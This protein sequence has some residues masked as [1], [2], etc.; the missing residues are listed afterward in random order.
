MEHE[1]HHG[2][3]KASPDNLAFIK[4]L[5]EEIKEEVAKTKEFG[6]NLDDRD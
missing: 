1:M 5:R 2:K 4:K 3:L 6:V